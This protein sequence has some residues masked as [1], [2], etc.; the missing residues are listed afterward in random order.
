VE[1]V[2][3]SI[4]P[5]DFTK[6]DKDEPSVVDVK[7]R[8][9][10]SQPAVVERMVVHVD[11]A[12][13]FGDTSMP[14]PYDDFDLMVGAGLPAS[15]TYDVALPEPEEAAGARISADL[16][17]VIAPGEADR[18]L[19]RLARPY[20][21]DLAAYLLRLEVLYGAN[22]RKLTS[23]PLAVVSPQRV[24]I[25]SAEEIGRE[26]RR[27]QQ[28][29]HEIRQAIDRELA[30]R[31]QPT[32]HWGT[33]P[34]R[35]RDELPPSLVSVDGNGNLVDSGKNGVY[36]VNE[37]FW[38]PEQRIHRYL[39]SIEQRYRQV[40][41]ISAGASVVPDLLRDALP[42]VHATLAELPALR[43]EAS[44]SPTAVEAP[45]RTGNPDITDELV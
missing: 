5:P 17:Q 31:G 16:S 45:A 41:E 33:T 35:N 39:D 6:A 24:V 20:V 28:A 34:P 1:F 23:R 25:A 8:N 15:A 30:V 40:V 32:L 27:F 26:I 18:F 43:A 42:R 3:V 10:G 21:Q 44:T 36:I 29:V 2:D 12:V 22:D 13:R 37:N 14:M 9:V 7:V 4:L 11:R 19:V 38:N